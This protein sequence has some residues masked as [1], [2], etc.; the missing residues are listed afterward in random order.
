[1]APITIQRFVRALDKLKREVEAGTLHERDYDGRLAR[2]I[3]ELRERNLDADRATA[4]AALAE[5]V[6]RGVITHPVRA[7]IEHRLGLSVAS[8]TAPGPS[9]GL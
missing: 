1:M 8:E 6:T 3:Q 9:R 5:A 2:I 7:H 4:T